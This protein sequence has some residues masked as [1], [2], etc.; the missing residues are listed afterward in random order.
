MELWIGLVT[1]HAYMYY[2]CVNSGINRIEAQGFGE[3]LMLF[4]LCFPKNKVYLP[5]LQFAY[6]MIC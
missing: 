4:K 1:P 2:V 3:E 5:N 6:E